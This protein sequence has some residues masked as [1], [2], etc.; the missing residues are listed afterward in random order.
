MLV[1]LQTCF[2]VF[3]ADFPKMAE[4]VPDWKLYTNEIATL[5]LTFEL[6]IFSGASRFRRKSLGRFLLSQHRI[7]W[8]TDDGLC[9]E[10]HNSVDSAH[11][12]ES[13]AMSTTKLR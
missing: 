5:F 13:F 3:F 2:C 10:Y 6:S 12:V 1:A 4:V 8:E 11:T 7:I 9:P